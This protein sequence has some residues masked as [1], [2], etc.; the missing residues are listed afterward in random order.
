M[1]RFARWTNI[2]VAHSTSWP[3]AWS[4]RSTCPKNPPRHWRAYDTTALVDTSAWRPWKDLRRA[5]N[6]L[7]HQLLLA[8]RLCEAG[9]AFITVTDGGWDMHADGESPDRMAAFPA[10]GRLLDHALAAFLNDVHDRGLSD[11]ILLVVSGEMGRTP[12]LNANG[13]RDHYGELTP[14]LLAGGG[15]AT[16]RV[17]GETDRLGERAT[18]APWTP[19][20]LFATILHSAVDVTRLRLE[21]N[22][23]AGLLRYLDAH[24]PIRG[25]GLE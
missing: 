23:P 22:V 13:G 2:V 17:I 10:K 6:L 25:L 4:T 15:L 9:C 7:G 16:G 20:N 5:T 8:R 18:D 14:L 12:K 1:R 11:K 21:T 24:P 19:A 3:A